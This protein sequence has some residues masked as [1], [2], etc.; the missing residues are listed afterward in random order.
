MTTW[1][2]VR[3]LIAGIVAGGG[4]ALAQSRGLSLPLAIGFGIAC[5][6]IVASLILPLVWKPPKNG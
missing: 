3:R 2:Q 5:A 1:H 6:I 4:A